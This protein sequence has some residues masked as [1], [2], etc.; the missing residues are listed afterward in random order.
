M[1]WRR[2]RERIDKPKLCYQLP[3]AYEACHKCRRVAGLVHLPVNRVGYFCDKCCPACNEI[4]PHK[5]TGKLK[6]E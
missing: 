4:A 5:P 6:A 1:I 2:K 3:F